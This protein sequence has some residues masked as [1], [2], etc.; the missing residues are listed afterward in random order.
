MSDMKKFLKIVER[1]D[2]SRLDEAAQEF[3]RKPFKAS[4]VAQHTDNEGNTHTMWTRSDT[5]DRVYYSKTYSDGKTG[6]SHKGMEPTYSSKEK[7]MADFKKHVVN[8]AASLSLNMNGDT[9]S[10]VADMFNKIMGLS[11]PNTSAP[12]VPMVPPMTKSIGV[13][14]KMSAPGVA[15]E[16]WANQDKPEYKD[17]DYMTKDL[18]GGLNKPKKMVKHSYKQGDNPMAMEESL[19]AEYQKF[20]TGQ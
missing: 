8:E 19:M 20:K 12:P 18:A 14:D 16:D 4:R 13:V 5:G 11:S 9:S 10:D 7:A 17:V 3:G 6:N 15:E 2:A 1:A